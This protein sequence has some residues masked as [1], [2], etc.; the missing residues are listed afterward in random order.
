MWKKIPTKLQKTANE[1]W[2]SYL[3][4]H[5]LETNGNFPSSLTILYAF[6]L[7]SVAEPGSRV[8]TSGQSAEGTRNSTAGSGEPGGGKAWGACPYWSQEEERVVYRRPPM[9]QGMGTDIGTWRTTS[10]LWFVTNKQKKSIIWN[11]HK[12][13][14][15][16]HQHPVQGLLATNEQSEETSVQIPICVHTCP[17]SPPPVPCPGKKSM[18]DATSTFPGSQFLKWPHILKPFL[19]KSKR[20]VNQVSKL[21]ENDA[22]S[23]GH[24]T[25]REVGRAR[26]IWIG[27]VMS[28]VCTRSVLMYVIERQRD[29]ERKSS[30]LLAR[31][32]MIAV[33]HSTR[34]RMV[35]RHSSQVSHTAGWDATTWTITCS[36]PRSALAVIWSQVQAG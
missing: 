27:S 31:L 24:D 7:L 29:M 23:M 34:L 19:R 22:L 35:T 28:F 36:L 21:T 17:V 18:S 5:K 12:R 9:S 3:V 30:M 1:Q 6:S 11:L 15:L 26:C 4:S 13:N 33:T 8:E 16:C 32:Y 14:A 10:Q 20:V 2:V 25:A